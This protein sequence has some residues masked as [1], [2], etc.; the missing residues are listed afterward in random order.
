M[1]STLAARDRWLALARVLEAAH[2]L[3]TA[4]TPADPLRGPTRALIDQLSARLV[5]ELELDPSRPYAAEELVRAARE[6][7]A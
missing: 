5:T 1:E 6:R 4:M 7:A 3:E 2:D